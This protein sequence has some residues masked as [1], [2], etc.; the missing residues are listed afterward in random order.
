MLKQHNDSKTKISNS[1]NREHCKASYIESERKALTY[2]T[3]T[4]AAS[5]TDSGRKKGKNPSL[6]KKVFSTCLTRHLAYYLHWQNPVLKTNKQDNTDVKLFIQGEK[7]YDSNPGQT[8]T[9]KVCKF[10][11]HQSCWHLH[12]TVAPSFHWTLGLM[13][14]NFIPHTQKLNIVSIPKFTSEVSC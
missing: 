11:H 10:R 3:L 4:Q 14:K 7:A 12:R 2:S 8:Q 9:C 6:T 13:E 5:E 1:L